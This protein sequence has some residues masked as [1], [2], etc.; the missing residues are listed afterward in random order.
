M[1]ITRM[2]AAACRRSR[3]RL[4][5]ADAEDLESAATLEILTGATPRAAVERVVMRYR[6]ACA[7]RPLALRIDVAA[8][9]CP[10]D[11]KRGAKA[12]TIT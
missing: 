1:N 7:R 2:I 11:Y 6:R 10:R 4:Q 12:P 3:L 5:S 8:A 9:T